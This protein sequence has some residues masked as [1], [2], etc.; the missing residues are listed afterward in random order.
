MKNMKGMYC[1]VTGAGKG[2]GKAIAKRFLA[3]E[4]AGVAILEWDL[5]LA[6]ATAK[7][8]DPTGEKV[9]AIKCNVADSDMVKAAVDATVAKFGRVDVL[10]NNAGVT[11][12]R[13][14]HKMTD[15]EWYTV[16][17]INLN[18][19]YNLCKFVVPIMREQESGAIVNISST[20]LM[21]NPGQANYA[22]T[23]AAMQGFTRTMAKELG[24]KNVRMNCIA[25]GYIDTE[26]MRA[27]GEEKFNAAVAR[28]PMQRMADPDEI[29]SLTAFLCT[30]DSSWVSG[31]TIF[32]SGGAICM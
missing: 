28:H 30:E 9:I 2:I 31:Q 14:F 15:D 26:M 18:G 23:K 11:R 4:A 6:E 13:I 20:S 1:I 24:R 22:A 10:V 32:A 29:A 21:G 17:N 3:E 7:E 27:V 19:M 16:I 5:A 8:L 25:P 12:D